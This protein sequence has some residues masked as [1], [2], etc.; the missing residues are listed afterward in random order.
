MNAIVFKHTGDAAV[1]LSGT[2]IEMPEPASD[3]VIVKVMARPINPS[4]HMFIQG[5]YR[6]K[7]RFPQVAGLEGSGII[8][9]TGASVKNFRQGD[10]VSFRAVGTWA[11]YAAVSP[12][13]LIRINR[14]LTFEQSAQLALNPVT[15]FALLELSHCNSGDFLLMSAATSGLSRLVIQ[16]AAQKGIQV[17]CLVRDLGQK[18][19]LLQTGVAAVLE[20]TDNDLTAKISEIAGMD[21]VSAF[22]DAVGGLLLSVCIKVM[23]P[24]A[25]II[26]YGRY[27]SNPAELFTADLIYRNLNMKGFGIAQWLNEQSTEKKEQVFQFLIDNIADNK[28]ILPRTSLFKLEDFRKAVAQDIVKKSG[29]IILFS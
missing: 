22:L 15:A 27:D 14:D 26:L 2:E 20:Q 24:N 18:D 10:H 23:R 1:V 7:P 3:S 9:S 11:E 6:I 21:G 19:D 28:L 4:D 12:Q 8:H 5:Q 13:T 16:L 17:I 29:K 25:S